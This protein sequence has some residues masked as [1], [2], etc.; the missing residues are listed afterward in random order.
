MPVVFLKVAA[1][2]LASGI[3]ETEPLPGRAFR[4]VIHLV[5][6][7]PMDLPS[8]ARGIV[9]KVNSPLGR[10]SWMLDRYHHAVTAR[11]NSELGLP[12][13]VHVHYVAVTPTSNP[14]P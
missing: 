13:R 9:G 10:R 14:T 6:H 1:A 12:P 3:T 7:A 5:F 4:L 8:R 11:L 2:A